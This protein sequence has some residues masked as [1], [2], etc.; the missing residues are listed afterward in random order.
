MEYRWGRP[1][2]R[3][4]EALALCLLYEAE[5]DPRFERGM[6]RWVSRVRRE[7]ALSHEQVE[8]L[9]PRARCGLRSAGSLATLNKGPTLAHAPRAFV[10]PPEG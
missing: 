5:N 3:G 7:P 6:R 1:G 8:L 10:Q 4:P 2:L 9:P